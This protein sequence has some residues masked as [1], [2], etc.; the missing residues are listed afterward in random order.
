MHTQLHTRAM[1]YFCPFPFVS[2]PTKERTHARDICQRTHGPLKPRQCNVTV[3]PPGSSSTQQTSAMAALA[4]DSPP[5]ATAKVIVS[6]AIAINAHNLQGAHSGGTG[7]RNYVNKQLVRADHQALW[8]LAMLVH[9][10]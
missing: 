9:V 1:L 7:A 3:P 4:S 6:A 8:D 10:T 5:C 2:A